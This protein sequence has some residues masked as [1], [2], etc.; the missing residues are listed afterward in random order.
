M[1]MVRR[2][3]LRTIATLGGGIR[4]RGGF[5]LIELLV[6]I[7]II[8]ILASMLLP[9]LGHAKES[10][11]RI[12]CTN[13]LKQIGLA[14]NMYSGDNN[15][16]FPPRTV[17]SPRWPTL[18]HDYAKN[19]NLLVCPT[20]AMIG[21]P[22]SDTNSSALPDR[23]PRSY[24]FNGWNDQFSN[25]L[26]VA[27]SLKETAILKPTDTIIYGEKKNNQ[28]IGEMTFSD[29]YMDL[30]EGYGNDYDRVEHGRHSGA[31]PRSKGAGSNFAFGDY[32]VRFLRYG[33]AVWPVNLWPVAELVRQQAAFN[34]P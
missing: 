25:A 17:S 20:D 3:S 31:N 30:G 5:T 24:L 8:A 9:A 19:L 21:T 14:L 27:N 33:N 13:N 2:T 4:A 34:P 12:R 7:A 32:G 1:Q 26:T 11:Y 16:Y 23:S 10:A 28:G 18:L 6:V 29:Y 15:G 22:L